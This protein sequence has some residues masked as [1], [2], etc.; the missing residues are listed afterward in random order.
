MSGPLRGLRV[1]ELAGLGP[2]PFCAMM[3]A[4][5]GADVVRIERPGT[6]ATPNDPLLR[7]RRSI[8]LDLKSDADLKAVRDLCREAEVVIEGFRPGVMER[9]GLGPDVLLV[10][11]PSLVYARMTG[12]GQEG[13][14]RHA[15]GHDINYIAIAGALGACGPVGGKPAIPLNIIG[16]MGGGAMMLAFGIVS[17]VLAVRSG[18]P[19]Q[20]LDCAMTD[21]A[22]LLMAMIWG[23]RAEGN[24]ADAR[25]TNL[26]DG[27]APYYDS[28]ATSDGHYIALGAIEPQ[29][30]ALLR[31]KTGL[32]DD[33]DFDAQMDPSQW[34]PLKDKLTALF[35]TKSR[36]EWCAIMEMTDV[37]FA[38]ILSLSEAPQH[39]HNQARR[40]F[41]DV[42]GT[43][44]P[45]PAPRYSA[46]PC[47]PPVP[48][49]TPGADGD[50]VLA[51]LAAG[52]GWPAA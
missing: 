32:T 4:D 48:P 21:G 39:P 1:V 35:K 50:S 18:Q 33:P 29:F 40:T 11:N 52:S 7:N 30:Y 47:Q 49:R 42:G 13:P 27:G 38:P 46:T 6:V 20:V 44:Q 34:G 45:A 31:E 9:L 36:D 8:M 16:D 25:G 14:L 15:A 26:L 12:W 23:F 43:I 3:L 41:I 28:Y 5:H 10:D 22:A 24:W 2:A 37:C 17:A 19:G 51:R